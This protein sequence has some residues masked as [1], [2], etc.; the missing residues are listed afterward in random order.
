M[1][2]AIR[3]A[4]TVEND[5]PD[6]IREATVELIQTILEK[7]DLNIDD[8]AFAQFSVTEDIKSATPAKFARTH[9]GWHNVPMMVYREFEFE[10]GLKKCIR[11]LIVTNSD[12]K[13]TEIKHVYLRKSAILRPDLKN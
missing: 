13:Q 7:N 2:R 4:T 1:I 8:F 11:L 12:K 5:T 10:G 6:E 9:A 3:G